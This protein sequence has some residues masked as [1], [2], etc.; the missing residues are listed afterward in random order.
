M[1]RGADSAGVLAAVPGVQRHHK[2]VRL[3]GGALLF[4]QLQDE[5]QQGV[6]SAHR[7]NVQGQAMPVFAHGGHAPDLVPGG[8]AQFKDKAQG[9]FVAAGGAK[10]GQIRRARQLRPRHLGQGRVAMLG[11]EIQHHPRGVAQPQ[12]PVFQRTVGF[13]NKTGALRRRPQARLAAFGRAGGTLRQPR[14][15]RQHQQGKTN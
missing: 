9:F 5:G 7:M 13:K 4:L 3:V 15:R 12:N 1:R 6:G 11:E 10:A 8:G 2:V 14:T